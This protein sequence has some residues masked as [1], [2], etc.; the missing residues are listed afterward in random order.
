M[1][2]GPTTDAIVVTLGVS[3]IAKDN[4]PEEG[5]VLVTEQPLTALLDVKS[6]TRTEYDQRLGNDEWSNRPAHCL[7]IANIPR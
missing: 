6:R 4:R 1:I 5:A 3:P 7:C 2:W